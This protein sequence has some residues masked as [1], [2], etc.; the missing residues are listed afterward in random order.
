MRNP[1]T[2]GT[3]TISESDATEVMHAID[4]AIL[5]LQSLER[6]PT[7]DYVRALLQ[8]FGRIAMAKQRY[9]AKAGIAAA[10]REPEPEE[11]HQ[12]K[13]TVLQ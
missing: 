10:E 5:R 4:R 7:A 11:F 1:R 2:P 6:G 13:A 12:P 3:V 8:E 9:D